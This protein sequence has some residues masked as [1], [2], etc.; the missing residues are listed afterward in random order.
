MT[1]DTIQKLFSHTQRKPDTLIGEYVWFCWL[2]RLDE[3][4]PS[5][6]M[7]PKD[8]WNKSSVISTSMEAL[9]YHGNILWPI[10][11]KSVSGEAL[12]Q[13][14]RLVS[15]SGSVGSSGMASLFQAA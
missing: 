7:M 10:S 5:C 15:L 14:S 9:V 12:S 3:S 4:F 11:Y 6:L 13:K 2:E 1:S 8:T